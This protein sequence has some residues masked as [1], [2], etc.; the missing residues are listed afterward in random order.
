MAAKHLLAFM[1]HRREKWGCSLELVCWEIC[2]Q[3]LFRQPLGT[4]SVSRMPKFTSNVDAD[5]PI[6]ILRGPGLHAKPSEVWQIVLTVQVPAGNQDQTA[7]VIAESPEAETKAAELFEMQ[8]LLSGAAKSLPL[9]PERPGDARGLAAVPS[10]AGEASLPPGSLSI[11]GKATF[12]CMNVV[13]G[14]GKVSLTN[15]QP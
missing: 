4:F 14:Q 12:F 5:L 3:N 11:D 9:V 7:T 2:L 10:K 8:F 1:T 15:F 6:G 13:R